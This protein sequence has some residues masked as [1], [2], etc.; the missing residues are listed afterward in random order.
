MTKQWTVQDIPDLSG[1]RIIVTG[2]NSGVGYQATRV[3]ARKGAAVI[4]AVRD[5]RKGAEA[6][7]EIHRES[8]NAALEIMPLDLADLKSVHAFADL[9]RTRFSSLDVLLNNA[10][11]MGIP[12]RQTAQGFE[13]QFGTNHLG[14]FALTG[15]LLP[16]ILATPNA[17]V[18]TV[19]SYMHIFGHIA[20][21]DLNATKGYERWTA[22][23][24]SKLANLLFA[25]ELQ[26]RFGQAGVSAISVACH[27]GYAA[28]NLQTAGPKMDG[29]RIG[30]ALWQGM[31]LFAQSAAAG[32]L[33]LLYAATA[34]GLHGGEY[35]GPRQM[36]GI[37]GAPHIARSSVRSYDEHKARSLWQVSEE[38]TGVKIDIGAVDSQPLVGS[39]TADRHGAG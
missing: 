2:A 23:C 37:R 13:M 32:A 35:I 10:G 39:P 12:Y 21:K 19:S 3:L 5:I 34:P 36:F 1:K 28:T 6:A 26:R 4:L 8:P 7:A 30:Q 16:T 20:F 27:P 15:L 38:L 17:R 31:N 11:V 25:Y 33:P 29:S 9:Y 22:Y 14:H 18:V 24:Q